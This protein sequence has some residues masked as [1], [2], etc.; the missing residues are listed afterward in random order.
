M[1][2]CELAL[3]CCCLRHVFEVL[4]DQTVRGRAHE[5]SIAGS[6]G[7][8]LLEVASS[9][10][11]RNVHAVNVSARSELGFSKDR[12]RLVTDI[13]RVLHPL[14]PAID[15]QP[16]IEVTRAFA[17]FDELEQGHGHGSVVRPLAGLPSECSA[18]LHLYGHVRRVRTPEFV[19][20]S[21]RIATREADHHSGG[22]VQVSW[23][24]HGGA[25]RS[26]SVSSEQTALV[27]A[28]MR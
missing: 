14:Q 2:V 4:T 21:E 7:E 19:R 5:R 12:R 25:F 15:C 28:K 26:W 24:G 22:A 23:L 1:R 9:R 18:A 16:K 17:G 10:L 6:F 27:K 3:T 11:G 13:F 20:S 8:L